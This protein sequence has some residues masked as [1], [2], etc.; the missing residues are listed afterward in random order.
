M[1][2]ALAELTRQQ[3]PNLQISHLD[4]GAIQSIK[5]LGVGRQG[6]DAY[7]V[8]YENARPTGELSWILRERFRWPRSRLDLDIRSG[9]LPLRIPIHVCICMSLHGTF[10]TCRPGLTMSVDRRRSEVAGEGLERRV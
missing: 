1:I 3:L 9:G 2:P 10:E 8:K 6:E 4:L 7:T 5:F